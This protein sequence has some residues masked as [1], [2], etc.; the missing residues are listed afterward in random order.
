[1]EEGFGEPGSEEAGSAGEEEVSLRISSERGAGGE[2][3][4]EILDW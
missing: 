4:V 2:D 1:M 3:V